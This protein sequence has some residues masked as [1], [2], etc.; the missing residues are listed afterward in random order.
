MGGSELHLIKNHLP[1][2]ISSCVTLKGINCSEQCHN[3]TQTQK[4]PLVWI[5]GETMEN[6]SLTKVK[7]QI[8]S[9]YSQKA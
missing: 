7:N 6:A 4:P 9:L 5:N 2:E 3:F 1:H 8:I